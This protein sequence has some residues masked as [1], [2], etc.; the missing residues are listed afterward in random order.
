MPRWTSIIIAAIFLAGI[1]HAEEWTRFRGP[2]GSGKGTLNNFPTKITP[3]DYE[4]VKKIPGIGLSSP[5]IWKE[6]LFITAVEGDQRKVICY[7]ALTGKQLWVWKDGFEEHNLHKNNNFASSTPTVDKERVYLVWGSG[8]TAQA[9]ALSHSGGLIWRKEWPDF[10]SDH[11][12]ATSPVLID[13]VLVF[14]TDS[15]KKKTSHVIAVQPDDGEILWELER[16]TPKD[17]KKHFTAYNTFNEMKVGDTNTIVTL[18]SNVGWKGLNPKDGS[19]V[20]SAPG[21]YKFRTVGSVAVGEDGYLFSTFGSGGAGKDATALRIEADG[22]VKKLYS[23][24]IKDG[25]N[26]VPSTLIHDGM[27]FLWGDGGVLTCRDLVS[28]KEIFRERIGGNFFCSPVIGDGKI[29]CISRAGELVIVPASKDFEIL[30]R[31]QLANNGDVNASPAIANG[32]LYI[33][34]DTHLICIKGE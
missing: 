31:S 7:H 32:S 27:L 22:K 4:W 16:P 21:G 26:Y 5:V 28:S 17:Q 25:V 1:I 2:N 9:L 14:H 13:G 29:F 8:E 3:A 30:G 33:R 24:G 34:T 6:K 10:T 15:V 18:Q 11:G 12:H 23:F 20:W 19:V